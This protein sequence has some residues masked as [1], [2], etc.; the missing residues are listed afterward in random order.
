MNAHV[1]DKPLLADKE[2]L[3]TER[4]FDEIAALALK[5]T[6]IEGAGAALGAAATAGAA[7]G[8]SID[9][10]PEANDASTVKNS[11]NWVIP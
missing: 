5:H 2:F 1:S 6:G 3:M 7:T 10:E 4:D 8:A 9:I 11:I